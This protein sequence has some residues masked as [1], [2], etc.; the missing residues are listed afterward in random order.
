MKVQ[1]YRDALAKQ[2]RLAQE[3]QA[4]QTTTAAQ[5]QA[6]LRDIDGRMRKLRNEQSEAEYQYGEKRKQQYETH[7]AACADSRAVIQETKEVLIL[8]GIAKQHPE[9]VG[10]GKVYIYANGYP[11]ERI[12]LASFDIVAA[13][14]HKQIGAWIVPNG[15]PKNKFSLAVIG[16][17]RFYHESLNL[18]QFFYHNG[19]HE[20]PYANIGAVLRSAPT[21]NEL[22]VWFAKAKPDILAD[23]LRRHREMEARYEES[24][25]LL[26]DPAWLRLYLEDQK[27]YY[28]HRYSGGTQQPE[29]QAVLHELEAIPA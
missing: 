4:G 12:D 25:S 28:E 8:M 13:D 6:V 16:W 27:D 11:R 9:P 19:V 3:D 2:E 21:E 24:I 26:N 17:G 18:R 22:K 10:L 15:K 7:I 14:D 5:H 1:H 29:Y 20:E 23:Y